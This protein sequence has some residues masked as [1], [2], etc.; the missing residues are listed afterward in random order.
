M[1]FHQ[2]FGPQNWPLDIQEKTGELAIRFV[3]SVRTGDKLKK[4]TKEQAIARF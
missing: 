4:L 1:R 2:R 3:G